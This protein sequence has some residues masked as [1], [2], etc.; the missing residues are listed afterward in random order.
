M[1]EEES[2]FVKLPCNISAWFKISFSG[3]EEYNSHVELMNKRRGNIFCNKA[4]SKSWNG[5]ERTTFKIDRSW[6]C[7]EDGENTILK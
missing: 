2:Y 1:G 7:E 5:G 3:D 6:E 4:G